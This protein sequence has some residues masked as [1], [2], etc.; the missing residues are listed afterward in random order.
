M[1][2]RLRQLRLLF[3]ALRYGIR[4]IW[5]AAPEHHKLH[6][7]VSLAAR[8]RENERLATHLSSALPR[9]APLA[10]AFAQLVATHPDLAASTLH[11]AIDAIEHVEEPLTPEQ[12]NAALQS[13]LGKPVQSLFSWI[14]PTPCQN[15]WCEQTH[16][17]RL[18]LLANG[19]QMVT[20]RVL[21]A[22][23]A[24]EVDDEAALLCTVARW[25]ERFS[26]AARKLH[27]RTLAQT[28]R[29]D[30]QR[31]FDLRAQAANLSQSGH[32]LADDERVLVPDVIW[33]FCTPHTLTVEHVDTLRATDV[34]GL[35][36]HH[37]NVTKVAAHLI[38]VVTQQAFEHG[39]F[40]A[41]FDARRVAV[42]VEP[43]TRGRL[44]FASAALMTS[45]SSPEREFFVHGATALFE[46]DYGR[47]ANLHHAAGHVPVHARPEQIEAELRTRS[48]AHFADDEGDRSAG[49]LFHHLLHAV[50]PFGGAVSPRLA[51]AQRTF[52]QAEALARTIHPDV[53]AW[54]I[55]KTTLGD[56]AKR[57]LGHHG[58]IK[59]LSQELPHLAQIAP[60]VPQLVYRFMHHHSGAT[61]DQPGAQAQ[62][63]AA[64]L[65]ALRREHR[66]TRAL[67]V[68]C[69]L[70]GT[71]IGVVA[72]LF[73]LVPA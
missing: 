51:A 45:L 47:L 32:H 65:E 36:M 53:D 71:F 72:T 49:A 27:L 46:Q 41:A 31:R 68:A 35:A 5:L 44:V 63:Q 3:C 34:A 21:R 20:V 29:D 66:R 6:W 42:S 22:K 2:S 52:G 16:I 13:A 43:Q 7:I 59:R 38:E 61:H 50:Q 17:A 33:D 4:L 57:D 73:S 54:G 19:H 58:W 67:L 24:Q 30:L 69:A 10:S 70:S 56:I 60:R 28:L 12:L 9:L 55:A 8:V 40:H 25:L 14:D 23:Q 11:D 64:M 1:R 26:G 62:A 37:I 18:Q 15:G 48:E 39:F